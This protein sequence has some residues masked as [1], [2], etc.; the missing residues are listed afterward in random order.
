MAGLRTLACRGGGQL[1]SLARAGPYTFCA[2][3]GSYSRYRARGLAN[4]CPRAVLKGKGLARRRLL[5][6][7]DPVTNALLDGCVT[8]VWRP[9]AR[10][11]PAREEGAPTVE[12]AGVG[13]HDPTQLLQE[14]LT[15]IEAI[16]P[17]N[18]EFFGSSAEEVA[19]IAT[20]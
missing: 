15:Q 2:R 18:E 4:S 20:G 10:A 7:R 1:H 9:T 6:G 12:E 19:I 14:A 8:R 13:A 17:R 11:G 5:R 16:W 3:C